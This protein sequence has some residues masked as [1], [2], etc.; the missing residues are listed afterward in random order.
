MIYFY[1]LLSFFVAILL[2]PLFSLIALSS[3]HKWKGLI[4]HFGWVPATKKSDRKTLWLHALSMGEVVAATPVLKLVREQNPELTIVLS[5]TTDSGYAAALKM[6]IADNVFFHPLDCLPFSQLALKRINPDLHVVTD[7]GFWPGL[8]DLLHRKKVPILLFNGRISEKSARR[9]LLAGSLFKDTFQKFNHLGMQ[10]NNAEKAVLTLGVDRE[11]IEVMGDPKYD[12]QQPLTDAEKVQLRKTFKLEEDTPVWIAG[13]THAGE[14][15]IILDAHQQLKVEHPNLILILAPRR[16][17]RVEE[18]ATLLKKKSISFAL[19]SSLKHAESVILL[20][21]MGELAKV[22]TLGQVAFIG[23]SLVKP[24]GGHS[25]IEPLS[26]GLPVMYG[27]FIENIGHVADKAHG[28]G[29]T[30]TV[31]NS[32]DIKE[33]AYNFMKNK[34]LRQELAEKTLAFTT[35]QQGASG[36]MAGVITQSLKTGQP[37]RL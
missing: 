3:K 11:R 15:E 34:I 10:N 21:T 20:D 28:L 32:K 16:I 23:N 22:Y 7:T 19:R 35:K 1:H 8:I 2:L 13:S 24:G 9:Y 4:H 27:P 33:N 26:Y 37:V 29:L 14:E 6:N 17:E 31:R 25:L 18:V 12:A 36:K 5:V 30:I